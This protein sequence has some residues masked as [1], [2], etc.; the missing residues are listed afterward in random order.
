MARQDAVMQWVRGVVVFGLAGAVVGVVPATGVSWAPARR[1]CRE[2]AFVANVG[3][4]TVSTIDVRTRTKDPRDIAVGAS[5]FG[6]IATQNARDPTDI[7]VG[8][9]AFWVAITPNG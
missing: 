8:S 7:A 5:P 6:V 4:G 1:R 9:L 3:S 2:T